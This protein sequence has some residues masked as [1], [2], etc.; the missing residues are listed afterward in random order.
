MTNIEYYPS[1][2]NIDP[3]FIPKAVVILVSPRFPWDGWPKRYLRLLWKMFYN[4]MHYMLMTRLT[5][6]HYS[7]RIFIQ[8]NSGR[9]TRK[10]N[11]HSLSVVYIKERK[12]L[13]PN[14]F[15]SVHS[16]DLF[17]AGRTPRIVRRIRSHEHRCLFYFVK[18]LL[19]FPR[20]RVVSGQ[21]CLPY[22]M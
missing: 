12:S 1:V 8:N 17:S 19:G 21:P 16:F 7:I 4:N 2:P 3:S 13:T 6:S 11:K 14:D 15:H 18:S 9:P 20:I 22:G 10:P 5:R